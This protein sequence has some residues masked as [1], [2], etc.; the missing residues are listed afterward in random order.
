DPVCAP[1]HFLADLARHNGVVVNL[2]GEGADELFWGYPN[3]RR[4]WRLQRLHDRIPM[5]RAAK[6]MGLAL[7][8]AAGKPQTQPYD[9][10]DRAARG[11]PVFGGGAE[12]YGARL[13]Q[14]LL[15]PR[16]RSEFA[17]ASSWDAIAPIHARYRRHAAAPST[18][19]W[20][21]YLDL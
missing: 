15:S 7:L 1:V 10:L 3:W 18:L 5:P 6:S 2:V 13:K 17:G 12:G 11:Q 16:L 9:W 19:A 8:R 21:T 4:A 14:R 20:M